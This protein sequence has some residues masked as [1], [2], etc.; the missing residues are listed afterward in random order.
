MYKANLLVIAI[1]M[2]STAFSQQT[3]SSQPS[4]HETFAFIRSK[5]LAFGGG[6]FTISEVILDETSCSITIKYDDGETITQNISC[7]DVNGIS[8]KVENK[9]LRFQFASKSESCYAGKYIKKNGSEDNL[10]ST[11]CFFDLEK[12]SSENDF[13]Q[14]LI[15]AYK[16][17]INLC[18]GYSKSTS[19]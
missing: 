8:Y 17:L 3:K 2:F 13:Q 9:S 14:T 19:F 11:T 6:N 10:G 18:G 1:L 7:L 12:I 16:R 4:K 5:L 15:K